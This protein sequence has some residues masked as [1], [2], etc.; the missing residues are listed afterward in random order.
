MTAAPPT[1]YIEPFLGGGAVVLSLMPD[2][3]TPFLR[4]PGGKRKLAKEIIAHLKVST[5]AR[6]I[7]A[8]VNTQLIDLWRT[9]RDDA[10]DLLHKLHQHERTV[11][12]YKNL[13]TVTATPD[14]TLYLNLFCFN[15]LQRVNSK[16][17]F[18]TPPDKVRLEKLNL[19]TV[20]RNVLAVSRALR[21]VDVTF[22]AQG[23][24]NTLSY[25]Q[26]GD[27]VYCD[28]PYI[29]TFTWYA[30]GG[31]GWYDQV[32]LFRSANLAASA[33][34]RVTISNSAEAQPFYESQI[35]DIRYGDNIS[36]EMR[37]HPLTA[38]RSIAAKSSSRGP[39]QEILVT[40]SRPA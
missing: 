3:P 15:G 29:G 27:Y 13:R 4:W 21:D 30:K 1:T 18:N 22:L 14:V 31:F 6:F 10:T 33:G 32:E 11:E 8:D 9:V 19:D 34:A 37:I 16:G 24:G 5:P 35:M 39:A 36:T 20:A 28:P 7:L 25:V 38:H 26:G 12:A 23:Y 2:S 17:Q 40:L